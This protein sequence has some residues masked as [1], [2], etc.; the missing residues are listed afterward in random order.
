MSVISG[1]PEGVSIPAPIVDT[2]LLHHMGQPN[3][4]RVI[5]SP[6]EPTVAFTFIEIIGEIY[7]ITKYVR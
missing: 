5:K 7:N 3:K 4:G 1:A 6:V 2:V